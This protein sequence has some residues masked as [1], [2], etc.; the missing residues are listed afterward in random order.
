M[1][2]TE[3]TPT[4]SDAALADTDPVAADPWEDG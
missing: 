1:P 4:I 2:T 3:P